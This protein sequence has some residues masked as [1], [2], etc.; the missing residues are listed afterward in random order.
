MDTPDKSTSHPGGADAS[1]SSTSSSSPG[2]R[3]CVRFAD[4]ARKNSPR[5]H[6]LL[7]KIDTLGCALA[8]DPIVC[9]DVF[10]GAPLVGAYDPSRRVVVMNPSVPESALTQSEWTR[11]VTHELI[12]A[13]DH[14]RVDFDVK[15][16]SHVACTEVRAANLSGDCDFS[17]DLMRG[18]LRSFTMRGH[19]PKCVRRRAEVSLAAHPQCAALGTR[20]IVDDV[21]DACYR[22]TA[23][24][25]SN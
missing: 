18:G 22:D 25:A 23:P 19:Q 1:T 8:S 14:C 7:K 2:W 3:K 10:G 9:E 21:F 15:S 5:I 12:H 24:F 20:D 17:V 11:T 6:S 13:Y 16:C 4:Y